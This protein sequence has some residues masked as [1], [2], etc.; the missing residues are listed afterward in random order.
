MTKELTVRNLYGIRGEIT[1]RTDSNTIVITGK[2]RA[3]KSSFVNAFGHIFA[4]KAIKGAPD[5]VHEGQLEGEATYVDHDLGLSFTRK[6]KNGKMSAVEVRALDGAKYQDGTAI[7]KDRIGTVIVDVAEFLA[8]DEAKRRELIMSKSIFPEGFDMAALTAEQSRVEQARTDANREKSRLEGALSQLVPPSKETPDVEVSAADIVAEFEKA[9]EHNAELDRTMD[10]LGKLESEKERAEAEVSRLED[11][12]DAA[13]TFLSR[14]SE[15][16]TEQ[17]G[18]FRA[19]PERIDTSAISD[20]LGEVE[21]INAKVRAKAEHVRAK[22]AYD[23]AATLHTTLDEKLKTVKKAK[24]D[25]LALATFPHPG[26]SVDDEY[27]LLDGTPFV[28]VNAA[29]REVAAVAVAI[30]GEHSEEELCLVII[31][32]GDALDPTSLTKIDEMLTEAHF[33]GLIDRG[34][35]DMP[36]VAGIDVLE[37][38]DGQ[39]AK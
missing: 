26:L 36:S 19:G 12:L 16:L 39:V 28:N 34:R 25:G 38:A 20:R 21:E 14:A 30:S 3:G 29:D 32:N 11:A 7:L 24:F 18:A 13:R 31:K 5:P 4:H 35:P 9:R 2:N 15:L 17:M 22:A 8:M 10:A 37:L 33:T 1:H 6:W 23:A 27:V